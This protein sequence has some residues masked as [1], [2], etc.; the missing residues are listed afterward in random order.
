MFFCT[1]TC[2]YVGK[3]VEIENVNPRTRADP[4]KLHPCKMCR[5]LIFTGVVDVEPIGRKPARG[6]SDD[7]LPC[8]ILLVSSVTWLKTARRSAMSSRIL[9]SA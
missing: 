7:Y 6:L 8:L 1:C 2:G 5:N 9:R 4:G 3:T